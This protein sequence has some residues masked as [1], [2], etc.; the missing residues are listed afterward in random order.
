MTNG[1][2]YVVIDSDDENEAEETENEES[3]AEE[4]DADESED[5]EDD[6]MSPSPSS[7][8][9]VTR[10][11]TYEDKV[12]MNAL[13]FMSWSVSLTDVIPEPF[14]LLDFYLFTE[15]RGSRDQRTACSASRGVLER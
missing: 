11:P 2:S 8:S 15:G 12:P 10:V 4:E 6:E 9:S 14:L 3:K 7:M 1:T 5:F 13:L